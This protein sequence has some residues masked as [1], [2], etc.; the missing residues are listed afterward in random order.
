DARPQ[1]SAHAY[2]HLWDNGANVA[3]ELNNVLAIRKQAIENFSKNNIKTAQP[4][5]MLEDVFVPLYFFHRYQT[6][7]VTKVI[8]GLDYTYAIK[9]DGNTIVKRVD[10][11]TERKAL[12]AVL[13]TLDVN[14]I[15]IPKDKLGLFPPRA[16]GYGR[17]RESFKSKAGV[18]FDP[19][20]AVE[21][22]SNMTL[23]LLLHPQR[24]T[25]LVQHKSI[26]KSQLGLSE[27]LDELIDQSFTTS[28]KDSYYQE[29]QN[30][31][32]TQ[33]LN[34]LFY[35]SSHDGMYV[36]VNAIVNSK[37]DKISDIL[38][39]R[40]KSKRANPVQKVYDQEMMKRIAAF[41][42]NP[43]KFKKPS[44]PKIP[45]GSPIGADFD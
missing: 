15:A 8:G 19:F 4:Y 44:V 29:L 26:D 35:L 11:T 10:G 20:G 33:L 21:T 43:T 16:M 40:V 38:K 42:K 23:S 7:A 18:A 25:R 2:A 31:I 34:Q 14:R 45:D 36:Q 17:S 24:V 30:V 6:E 41:K 13:K 32:N 1:G 9:D 12:E 3:D 22:S 39:A 37:I 5:S 27:V 28:F